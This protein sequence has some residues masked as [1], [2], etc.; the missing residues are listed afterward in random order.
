MKFRAQYLLQRGKRGK[1]EN[2]NYDHVLM[3]EK[4][5]SYSYTHSHFLCKFSESQ[6]EL[7]ETECRD[8]QVE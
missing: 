4:K 2:I 1:R 5:I 7:H 6:H 3:D 8:S